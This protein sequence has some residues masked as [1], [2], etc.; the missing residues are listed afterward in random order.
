MAAE[1]TLKLIIQAINQTDQTFQAVENR[2][3]GWIRRCNGP[4]RVSVRLWEA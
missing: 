2:V 4:G 3:R 1:H